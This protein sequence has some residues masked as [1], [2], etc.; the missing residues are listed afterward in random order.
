MPV[1]LM[2]NDPVGG[3]KRLS[4]RAA[5]SPAAEPKPMAFSL[6]PSSR[7]KVIGSSGA[8]PAYPAGLTLTLLSEAAGSDPKELGPL[9][10]SPLIATGCPAGPPIT[11]LRGGQVGVLVG[12]D[13]VIVLLG[14]DVS[15]GRVGV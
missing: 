15:V 9:L 7:T 10:A 12:D 2:G 1:M 13:G 6:V 4:H 3:V 14:V 11:I 5:R 8:E